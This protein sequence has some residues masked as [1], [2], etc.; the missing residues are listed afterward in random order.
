MNP[1]KLLLP[2]LLVGLATPSA[3]AGGGF[4]Q[5]LPKDGTWVEYN[6]EMKTDGPQMQDMTGT[7]KLKSVGSAT[8]NGEKYRWFE[9]E[10]K[11]ES[12]GMKQNAV[13]KALIREKELKAGAKDGIKILRGWQQTTD[14]G[15]KMDPKELSETELSANGPIGFFFGTKLT[16]TKKVKQ[17][18]EIQYQKG[19][20]KLTEA[21]TGELNLKLNE[22]T[23]KG[24]KQ[25]VKQT[26]WKHKS[27]PTGTAALE[28]QM[29]VHN[30]DKLLM[31]M[32]MMCNVQDY[33]TG[34]KSSLPDKK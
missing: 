26:I 1:R 3:F 32:R 20:L 28:V 16:K 11:G 6:I 14:G 29:E 23:P 19:K 24:F 33:G 21:T 10:F 25:K 30:K 13:I 2:L 17:A 7:M 8:E 15:K 4:L 34:A 18:K 22:N 12:N 9:I 27:V 5:K 31:K